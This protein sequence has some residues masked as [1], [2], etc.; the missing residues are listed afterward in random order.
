MAGPPPFPPPPPP[1]A[2]FGVYDNA[3]VIKPTSGKAIASLICGLASVVG[4]A[5]CIAPAVAAPVG[6]ILGIVA[7]LETGRNGTRSG[8]GL[9]VA[10]VIVSSLATLLIVGAAGFFFL[11]TKA[12]EGKFEATERASLERDQELL[13]TRLKQYHDANGKSLGPGGP[14]LAGDAGFAPTP[15]EGNAPPQ[16]TRPR[17]SGMLEIKHLVGPGELGRG[18]G[19]GSTG[20]TLIING[21][22]SSTLRFTDWS[23]NVLREVEIRDIGKGDWFVTVQ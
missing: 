11:I 3:P 21:K 10:G 14:V 4:F 9:A 15:G 2:A 16:D 20:W 19:S 13:L 23:G 1:P 7:F 17:V 5:M 8:R 18:R 12:T 6:I 22:S